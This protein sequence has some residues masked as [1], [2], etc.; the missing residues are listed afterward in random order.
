MLRHQ[1]NVLRPRAVLPLEVTL[2]G[3]SGEDTREDPADPGDEPGHR[4]WSAPHIHGELL[5]LG[6]EGAQPTVAKYMRGVGE[7]GRRAGKLSFTIMGQ[8]SARW[9]I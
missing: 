5:K 4:L 7:G 6:I 1:L 3:R 8:A 2:P 9:T